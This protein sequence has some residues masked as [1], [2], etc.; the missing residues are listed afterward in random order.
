MLD[1][2]HLLLQKPCHP[3]VPEGAPLEDV[4]HRSC[5]KDL[6]FSGWV[7]LR[8]GPSRISEFGKWKKSRS[9]FSCSLPAW[10][11]TT[12]TGFLCLWSQLLL[13][14]LSHNPRY[15]H[16]H[17]FF[18]VLALMCPHTSSRLL[19]TNDCWVLPACLTYVC[20]RSVHSLLSNSFIKLSSVRCFEWAISFLQGTPTDIRRYSFSKCLWFICGSWSNI[21]AT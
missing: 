5:Q 7:W 1:S 10:S 11:W 13:G 2:C 4:A 14:N 3:S 8:G 20:F 17:S 16:N 9:S 19:G 18:C 12:V 21:Q 15:S 6:W